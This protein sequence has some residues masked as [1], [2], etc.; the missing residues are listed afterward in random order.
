MLYLVVKNPVTSADN[1]NHDL[2]VI[3]SWSNQWKLE[4][5]PDPTKQATE[6]LFSQ[7]N[8]PVIHPPLHFNGNIVTKVDKQKHL[9]LILDSKLSFRSHI[10]DKIVKTKKTIG[11]IKHLSNHLPIKTHK[12]MYKSLVRPHFDYC[13]EI[14]HIPPSNN[15]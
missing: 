7:K 3:K 8:I 13:S 9:G 12:I 10:I 5:N 11:M 6:V 14:F 4:F 2:E 1:L 15:G